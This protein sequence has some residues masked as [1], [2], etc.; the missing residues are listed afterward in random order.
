MNLPF[1]FCLGGN[2]GAHVAKRLIQCRGTNLG[3]TGFSGSWEL[4]RL[5][6]MTSGNLGPKNPRLEVGDWEAGAEPG[7]PVS[8]CQCVISAWNVRTP[9]DLSANVKDEPRRR[10]ARSVR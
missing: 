10:L 6:P 3:E 9:M 5:R 8:H 1:G 2:Q 4:S 7:N